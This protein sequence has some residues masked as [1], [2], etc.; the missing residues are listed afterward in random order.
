MDAMDRPVNPGTV[1]QDIVPDEVWEQ[2]VADGGAVDSM[3][4]AAAAAVVVQG[5][6]WV[7]DAPTL[8]ATF[9]L[10]T[11]PAAG[12]AGRIGRNTRRRSLVLSVRPNTVTT[13]YVVVAENAQQALSGYGLPIIQAAAPVRVNYAGDLYFAAFGA[14]V[15]VGFIAELDQG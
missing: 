10:I 6:S 2:D 14:D 13:A 8:A 9:G 3:I 7:R 15:Q 1:S 5:V 11:V 4:P 12:P